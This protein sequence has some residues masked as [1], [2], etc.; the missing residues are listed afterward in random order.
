[1]R[2]SA[3]FLKTWW[4]P[5]VAEYETMRQDALSMVFANHKELGCRYPA[6]VEQAVGLEAGGHTGMSV[7]GELRA[8]SAAKATS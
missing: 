3:D 4:V 2:S 8:A 1:M 5:G 6:A 7:E